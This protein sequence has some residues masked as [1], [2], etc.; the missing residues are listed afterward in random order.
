MLGSDATFG[1]RGA[2]FNSHG[3]C[4]IWDINTAKELGKLSEDYYVWWGYE[5]NKLLNMLGRN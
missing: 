3:T 4:E 2:Y 5:D 1:G